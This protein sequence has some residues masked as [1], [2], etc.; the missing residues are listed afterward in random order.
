VSD[1]QLVTDIFQI[2]VTWKPIPFLAIQ[3]A[4]VR[5]PAERVVEDAGGKDTSFFLFSADFRF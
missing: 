4:F 5:A 2:D 1:G 3:S